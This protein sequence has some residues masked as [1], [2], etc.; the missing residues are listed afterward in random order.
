LK[1]S[2]LV[3]FLAMKGGFDRANDGIVTLHHD[4]EHEQHSPQDYHRRDDFERGSGSSEMTYVAG[5]PGKGYSKK[6]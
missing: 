4:G 1:S 2:I 5:S 3:G 6:R